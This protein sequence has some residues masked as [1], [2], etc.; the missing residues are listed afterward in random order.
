MNRNDVWFVTGA[1]KGLGLNIVKEALK[2]GY[3][4]AATSRTVESLTKEISETEDR[5]YPL[6]MDLSSEEDIKRAIE[7]VVEHFGQ[8]DC[9]VNN[10]GYAQ[11]GYIEEVTD[12]EARA[13][14]EVNVF[15]L[16]SVIRNALPYLRG[17]GHGHIINISSK[18]GFHA[19]AGT[20]VYCASKY[21]VEG[22]SEALYFEMQPFG[23][24]VTAV[25]PGGFR[26]NF[27]GSLKM[28]K[29]LLEPYAEMHARTEEANKSYIG[30]QPGN[31]QKAA[32]VLLQVYESENPP[33][34]LFLGSDGYK[35]AIKKYNEVK[36]DMDEW[37]A[38]AIST[39]Y[40][41]E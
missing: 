34:H 29:N 40:Q 41:D 4:V 37:K 1:S 14:F 38:L 30:H 22:I 19:G 36:R 17:Q 12:Q 21:A 11:Y 39:D 15:G 27:Y 16:L 31:P 33:L 18:G 32:E 7:S 6:S 13:D 9:V 26:T 10:A 8:I 5:F 25:K 28:T 3:R 23:V 2:A 24:H 35:S 20:G